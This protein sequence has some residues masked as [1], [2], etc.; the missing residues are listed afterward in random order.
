MTFTAI[1]GRFKA[2]FI[3]RVFHVGKMIPQKKM[4]GITTRTIVT[5]MANE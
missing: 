3:S 4:S 2:S 1:I 5:M